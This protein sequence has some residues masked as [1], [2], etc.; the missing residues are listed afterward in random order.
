MASNGLMPNMILYLCREYNMETT[1]ATNVLFIWTAATN[2]VPIL[3][4]FL[5]DS[6]MG[7]YPMIGFGC[8]ISLLGMV[9]LWFTAIFPQEKPPVCDQM[10]SGCE[11][12]TAS[13]LMLLYSAFG[14]MSLGG[15]SIRASSLVFGADQLDKGNGAKNAGFGIPAVIMLL[16]ALSFFTASPF[17]VKP[18]ANTSLISGLIQVIVASYKN[19]NMKLSSQA[20]EEM[21]HKRKG[22][23]LLVLSENLRHP[24]ED[25]TTMPWSLRTV[26]QV[27]ELKALIKII[28]MWSTG[29][30]LAGTMSQS[31]FLVLQASSMDRHIS[32]NFEI[33]S[34]SFIIFPVIT[35]TLWIGFYDRILLPLAS[36]IKGKPC[37][38]TVKQR[39]GIGLLC[40]I[41]SMAAWAIV[42]GIRRETA[43]S[44]GISDDPRGVVK[45][46]AMWLLPYLVLC[47]LAAA[48][49]AIGQTEFYYI[50]LPKSMSSIAS[51]L[52]GVGMSVASL[53][54][55][56]VMNTVDDITKR[57]GNGGW[58]PSNINKGHYDYYYWLLAGL[59]MANFIYFLECCKA[60]GPCKGLVS[61]PLGEKDGTDEEG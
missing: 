51:T 8:I 9:L 25:S 22:S 7:R 4:A 29:I 46:S 30:I 1:A 40:C 14:L 33:P 16:S 20:T 54:A 3:G 12:A 19:R 50:E 2:F 44:E 43:I 23:M 37:Q 15:G 42:E 17:Y 58:I 28:P 21:Y 48:F 39:L 6:C 56:F 60:Y 57:G 18:K 32:P 41:A 26:D 35:V 55:S 11:S 34:G 36:K 59:N 5:A 49:N 13:Q 52:L 24:E 45:M 31:S 10:R 27:E 47:G 53:V 38:L 61:K